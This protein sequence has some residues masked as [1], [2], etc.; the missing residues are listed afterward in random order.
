[1]SG[2]LAGLAGRRT[3]RETTGRRGLEEVKAQD[4]P[5]VSERHTPQT[6]PHTLWSTGEGP[7]DETI[8]LAARGARDIT[9]ARPSVPERG[10]QGRPAQRPPWEGLGG[11]PAGP[12][13]LLRGPSGKGA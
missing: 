13:G 7:E 3:E 2:A 6:L 1:M 8:F 5:H 4:F 10:A 9:T 11:L 12:P